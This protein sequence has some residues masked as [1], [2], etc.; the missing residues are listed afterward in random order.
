[1]V[2]DDG[3][4]AGTSVISRETG[5]TALVVDKLYEKL[6]REAENAGYFLNPDVDFTK[7]LIKG[8]L[9]NE[10]RYGYW[11]CPCR[12]AT[13]ERSEDLDIVCPC[14][15]RD[16]DVTEFD[17]CFCG[18]YVSGLVAQGTKQIGAIPERR[19]GP[20]IKKQNPNNTAGNAAVS[21]P[22]WRCR[23]CG[24]ICSRDQ[25]PEIC[26]VCRASRDRFE[27]FR[28]PAELLTAK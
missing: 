11:A 6:K 9:A 4:G 14:D 19:P 13:G 28:A 12:L 26:P 3:E 17:T 5:V 18:L 2:S 25:P 27:I 10:K 15:Y 23:V 20:D 22:V 16:A 7:A 21:T 24:Y 8:L 1:M